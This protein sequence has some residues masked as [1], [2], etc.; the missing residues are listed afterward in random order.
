MREF[1]VMFRSAKELADFVSIANRQ[2]F[3]VQLV[4]GD[5]PH[6]AKSIMSLFDVPMGKPVTARI[7]ADAAEDAFFAYCPA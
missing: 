4:C 2:S 6:N 3:D 1:T 7:P 5:A